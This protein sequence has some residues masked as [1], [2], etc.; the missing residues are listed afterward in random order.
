M[1]KAD[2][3]FMKLIAEEV[4]Q[5]AVCLEGI[6]TALEYLAAEEEEEDPDEQD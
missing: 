5:I 4:N 3:P 1:R 6:M 2:V